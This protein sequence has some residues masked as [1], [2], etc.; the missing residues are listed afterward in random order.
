MNFKQVLE[1]A[2]FH[3]ENAYY[4]PNTCV[5]AWSCKTNLPSNTAFRGFGGPQGM[6]AGEH[7]VRHVAHVLGKDYMEISMLEI[8]YGKF[9][10]SN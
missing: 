9:Q 1:R 4:I 3:F 2:M 8:L 10:F 7:I 5:R 6:F